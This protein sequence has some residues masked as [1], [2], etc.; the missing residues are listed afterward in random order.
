MSDLSKIVFLILCLFLVPSAVIGY[1]TS[2]DY[3]TAKGQFLQLKAC[4]IPLLS[5]SP[6]G[7]AVAPNTH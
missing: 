4:L 7:H 1:M 2:A 3:Q 6:T 5:L